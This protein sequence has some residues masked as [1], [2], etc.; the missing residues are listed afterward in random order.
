MRAKVKVYVCLFVCMATK[1]I[2]LELVSSLTTDGFLAALHR[3]VGRRGNPAELFS[4]NGTN[5][6]G[7]DRELL[8]LFNLLQ[9]QILSDKVNEFCQPRGINWNFNP[10]KAPHHG[11]IWEANVK[12]MKS[13][14]HKTLNESY[15]TYEE[16]NT[17]L[18]QIESIL[19][20]RPLVQLTDDPFDY[21]ALSPGHFLVGRE[22]IAVAEPLYEDLK[23][24][25]LSRYQLVQKR[26]QHFW[27]RWSNEY[28]TGLQKRSKWYKDPTQLQNGL[29]VVLKEDNMPPKTWKLGRIIETHPGKDGIIRVVT[30]RTSNNTYKRPTTQIAVLPIDDCMDPVESKAK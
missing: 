22:L 27:Q 12:C 16:L 9:S 1:S 28:V 2:H 21:E 5:F 30:I 11:G 3:F 17:L 24:T 25:S 29:L 7:A 4:D 20:S 13:H 14:L 26:M 23:E 18:I 8:E 19:N 6:R 15:L 10:P